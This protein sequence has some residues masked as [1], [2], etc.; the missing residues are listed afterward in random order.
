MAAGGFGN[1]ETA[2]GGFGN[3]ETAAG[4]FGDDETAAG[5]FGNDEMAAGVDA[6]GNGNG[7]GMEAVSGPGSALQSVHR[8]M[9]LVEST[10]SV[11]V[12]LELGALAR[13]VKVRLSTPPH[14]DQRLAS[15]TVSCFIS[16][17]SWMGPLI[18]VLNLTCWGEGDW[19]KPLQ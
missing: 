3:D 14:L 15:P 7:L 6:D 11:P 19:C 16:Q 13:K 10:F 9:T 5:D 18:F 8:I 2:A 12:L 1:D 4:G 17:A